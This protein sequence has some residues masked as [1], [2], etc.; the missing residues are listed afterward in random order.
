M[1]NHLIGFSQRLCCVSASMIKTRLEMIIVPCSSNRK[2]G[3]A[4]PPRRP[5]AQRSMGHGAC[6]DR[7][8]CLSSATY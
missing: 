5:R 8:V 7:V 4:H 6:S 3:N 2:H 1:S